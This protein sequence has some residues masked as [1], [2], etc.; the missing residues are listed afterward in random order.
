MT[1]LLRMWGALMTVVIPCEVGQTTLSQ[2]EETRSTLLELPP[3]EPA[4]GQEVVL[5]LEA[6]R[7]DLDQAGDIGFCRLQR[8]TVLGITSTV[9]TY[10]IVFMQFQV[11]EFGLAPG[12][13]FDNGTTAIAGPSSGQ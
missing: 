10:I 5:F 9:I 1:I 7:R 2:L 6:T 11:T 12:P 8:A 13:I 3:T 4:A